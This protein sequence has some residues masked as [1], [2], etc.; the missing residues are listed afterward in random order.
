M[1]ALTLTA[2]GRRRAVALRCCRYDFGGGDELAGV[3]LGVVGAVDQEAGYGGRELLSAYGAVFDEE[4]GRDGSDAGGGGFQGG[5]ELG[6]GFG[7]GAGVV[8]TG[9]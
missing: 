6:A 9:A 3:A 1:T 5:A 8:V 2:L 4:L 7:G